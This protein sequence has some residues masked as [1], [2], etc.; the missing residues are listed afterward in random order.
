MENPSLE[1]LNAKVVTWFRVEGENHTA[2]VP[3][4]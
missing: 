4:L 3:V 2:L 1:K